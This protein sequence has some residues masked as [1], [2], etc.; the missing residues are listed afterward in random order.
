MVIDLSAVK[1]I[2][3]E[4]AKTFRENEK[5]LCLLDSNIGDGDHGVS[6]SKVARVLESHCG[7]EGADGSISELLKNSGYD[8]MGSVGGSSGMLW[9]AYFSGLGEGAE[10][11]DIIDV[12][13]L[14]K[15]F[16]SALAQIRTVSDAKAGDKTMMDAVLPATEALLK[17]NGEPDGVLD[18]AAAAAGKGADGTKNFIAKFGRAKN[19][20]E[21]SLGFK[22]AGAASA[23][24]FFESFARTVRSL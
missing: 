16:E 6:M 14:K 12:S 18:A 21:G 10:G 20:K 8:I 22:D 4:I 11:L 24:M 1:M 13:G 15:M 23:A 7:A 17:A 2:L 5:E 9:G 3:T 19:F